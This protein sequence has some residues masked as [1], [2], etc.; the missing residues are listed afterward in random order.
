ML[1]QISAISMLG[2]VT[3][4][5]SPVGST[6]PAVLALAVVQEEECNTFCHRN[7]CDQNEHVAV[8]VDDSEAN[9]Q[10]NDGWHLTFCAT[11][12]CAQKHGPLCG[13]TGT[14]FAASDLGEL[15]GALADLDTEGVRA[16]L[17]QHGSQVVVNVERSALQVVDCTGAVR[18]HLPVTPTLIAAVTAD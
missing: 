4:A 1:K 10:Q 18:A 8:G 14:Q 12:S 6:V 13:D 11:G 15:T 16:V 5:A 3:I 7:E 17:A 2:L 9:S